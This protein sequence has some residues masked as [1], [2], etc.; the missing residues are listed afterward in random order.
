MTIRLPQNGKWNTNGKSDIFGSLWSTFNI[1]LQTKKGVT[2]VSPRLLLTTN[3]LTDLGICPAFQTF[4]DTNAG[5]QYHWTTSGKYVWRAV[6][7][8]GY[9]DAFA[10]DASS[11]T[12]S[13]ASNAT[14]CKDDV[15]DLVSVG[16]TYQLVSSR[17]LIYF[18]TASTGV[19]LDV[20]AGA[21]SVTTGDGFSHLMCIF[22]SRVYITDNNTQIRS[23]TTSFTAATLT[24]SGSNFFDITNKFY[25]VTAVTFIKPTSTRIWVGSVNQNEGGAYV[26]A[27]DGSTANDPNEAYLVPDSSGI[28]ACIIKND[29]PWVIDNNGRLMYFNGGSFVEAPN[30]RL[31]VR[32]AKW[33]KNSL[34]ATNNRWIHPNGMQLVDGRIRILIN[35]QNY[36]YTALGEENIAS[37]IWEYDSEI[38]WYHISS[39]SYY[40]ASSGTVTDYGQNRVA[41]V[42]GMFFAKPDRQTAT[43]NGTMLV[44]ASHYSDATTQAYG[45]WTDDSNNTV[46]KYGY[47]VTTKI[48]SQ[49][50]QDTWQSV[51]LRYKKLLDSSDSFVVKYRLQE[52]AP[53]EGT[54][55]WT[56]TGAFTS[57]ADLS[58]FA[59]GD[60]V[61]ILNG[62][63]GGKC[64]HILTISYSNPTYTVT[65]DDT[66]TGATGTAKARFQKWI[67]ASQK[68]NDQTSYFSQ[69]SMQPQK[70]K[71]T[72]IQF[73]VCMQFKGDD[74]LYDL[75][76]INTKAE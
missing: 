42:G 25:P 29:A 71:G 43:T 53:V 4:T 21:V 22:G 5:I 67:K 73:K 26:F 13:G 15:S 41:G 11:G 58:T 28:L 64:A 36:D 27:W 65:L 35:G 52:V 56:S 54:I 55:T 75:S 76:I 70:T 24:T 69:F 8:N 33:L 59:V 74:E 14:S 32:N 16:K 3:N 62:T 46:Q 49:N 34:S 30:G 63:G 48:F 12:P 57:T 1:D 23:F 2:R 68:L 45:I 18:Y 17:G 61:E 40:A 10:K 72:W 37:G 38:G 20:Q 39:L 60:E 7:T 31:P 9:I 19:W 44:G 6:S 47:F 51:F 50:I 66:F